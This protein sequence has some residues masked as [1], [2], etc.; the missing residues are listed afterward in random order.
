MIIKN[1]IVTFLFIR[2][3]F[4]GV[5]LLYEG[6]NSGKVP[7]TNLGMAKSTKYSV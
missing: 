5:G 6:K 3:A 2:N 1:N 4:S 7:K